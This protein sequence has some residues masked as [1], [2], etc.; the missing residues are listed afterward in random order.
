[1]PRVHTGDYRGLNLKV[2]NRGTRPLTDFARQ[3]LF[4]TLGDISQFTTCLDLYAGSGALGI[5]ALSLGIQKA[6]FVDNSKDAITAI[7]TNMIN[8]Y[9]LG[10]NPTYHLFYQDVENFVL[11]SEP[12]H[13]D[14]I[15]FAPPFVSFDAKTGLLAK[16]LLKSEGVL[17]VEQ[18]KA[19]PIVNQ[20]DAIKIK[21]YGPSRLYFIKN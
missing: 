10:F 4:N 18:P 1:M 17:I 13:Y 15:F 2:A 6:D 19:L 20:F 7:K 11:S 14:L 12:N 16:N 3:G 5:T 8:I 21:T 9:R